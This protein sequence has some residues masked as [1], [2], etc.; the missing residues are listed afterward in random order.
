[1]RNCNILL[2]GGKEFSSISDRVLTLAR[3]VFCTLKN[4]QVTY[5]STKLCKLPEI[6]HIAWNSV[7]YL[8]SEAAA[9]VVTTFLPI[10]QFFCAFRVFPWFLK[11]KRHTRLGRREVFFVSLS[12]EG[13]EWPRYLGKKLLRFL[14]L[15][16]QCQSMRTKISVSSLSISAV[17]CLMRFWVTNRDVSWFLI[18]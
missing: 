3:R 11:Q 10:G 7:Q 18:F 4:N 1:M 14:I 12:V 9:G 2:K 13:K 15:S 6:I 17:T 16:R 5:F 8:S